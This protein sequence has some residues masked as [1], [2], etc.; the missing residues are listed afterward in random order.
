MI[1]SSSQAPAR[2]KFAP[3]CGFFWR[4]SLFL[5]FSFWAYLRASGRTRREGPVC[6]VARPPPPGGKGRRV[7]WNS[8]PRLMINLWAPCWVHSF[9]GRVSVSRFGWRGL[10]DSFQDL[11]QGRLENQAL[12]GHNLAIHQHREFAAVA[13]HQIDLGS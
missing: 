12:L 8:Q 9:A 11:F 7:E 6:T 13:V 1:A 3:A 4:A 2:T 10:S 5:T